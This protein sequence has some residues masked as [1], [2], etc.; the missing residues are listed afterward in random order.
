[1]SK[2]VEIIRQAMDDYW[3]VIYAKSEK[4]MNSTEIKWRRDHAK[5]MERMNK[6]FGADF[7][8]IFGKASKN[9]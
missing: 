4:G 2:M 6:K 7:D 5:D 8:R 9:G 1:M 3:R